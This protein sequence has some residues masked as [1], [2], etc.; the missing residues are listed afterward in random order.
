MEVKMGLLQEQ[1]MRLAMTQE[2]RQAITM[3]QYNA[4]ELTE[5]FYM[6]NRLIILLLS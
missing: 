1:T 4:Q 3:L 5:F 2:L 6:N